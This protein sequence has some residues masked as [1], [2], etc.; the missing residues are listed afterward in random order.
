MSKSYKLE[1]IEPQKNGAQDGTY[2]M[3]NGATN[4]VSPSTEGEDK[5]A[6]EKLPAVGMVQVVSTT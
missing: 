2:K 1:Q 6:K 4:V 5:K 3:D